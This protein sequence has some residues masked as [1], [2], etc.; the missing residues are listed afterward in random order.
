MAN[1]VYLDHSVICHYA[2]PLSRHAFT[3]ACQQLTRHWR[4]TRMQP[5]L[6]YTSEYAIAEILRGDPRLASARLTAAR[7]LIVLPENGK[8]ESIAELLISGG[9]LMAKS[10]EAGMQ[11]SCAG[12]WQIDLFATWD[13][14]QIGAA[15][16]LH[17]LRN[18][19]HAYELPAPEIVNI[20]QLLEVLP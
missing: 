2:D 19:I 15:D 12:W 20:L 4:R 7:A 16:R 8:M 10:K 17:R 1:T 9:G 13:Y 3:R 18:A 14:A 6:T 5:A 11:F